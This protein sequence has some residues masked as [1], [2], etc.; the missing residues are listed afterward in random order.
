M[1]V[2]SFAR[3]RAHGAAKIVGQWDLIEGLRSRG[4]R[5]SRR[6]LVSSRSCSGHLRA[7]YRAVNCTIASKRLQPCNVG[8]VLGLRVEAS[9]VRVILCARCGPVNV[10]RRR[11][12]LRHFQA[13]TEAR[14]RFARAWPLTSDPGL[15]ATQADRPLLRAKGKEF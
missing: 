4:A 3:E 7:N 5:S 2:Q 11:A 6:G 10:R 8:A 14:M 1:N 15:N 13:V 12:A 9:T